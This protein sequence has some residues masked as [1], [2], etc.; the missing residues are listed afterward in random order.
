[1]VQVFRPIGANQSISASTSSASS[2]APVTN[3]ITP[4]QQR[5]V[6]VVNGGDL[7]TS[8]VAFACT[9]VGGST[10]TSSDSP[11]TAGS[12]LIIP[13]PDNH[14]HVNIIATASIAVYVQ[15]GIMEDA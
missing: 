3:P 1:M 5:V 7:V 11:I 14:T 6:R 8:A 2:A 4:G 10:A 9:T 13:Y 12:E 15:P